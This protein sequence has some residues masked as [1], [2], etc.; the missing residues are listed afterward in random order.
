[1]SAVAPQTPPVPEE[2][3]QAKID[4]G[5]PPKSLRPGAQFDAPEAPM[6]QET[7]AADNSLLRLRGHEYTAKRVVLLVGAFLPIALFLAGVVMFMHVYGATAI[8]GWEKVLLLLVFFTPATIIF[9]V[10]IRAVY[11][12]Q[13]AKDST[14]HGE[15]WKAVGEVIKLSS[16]P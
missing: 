5:A 8:F 11:A 2:P 3:E 13:D 4:G 12:V 14:P 10:L 16:K 6:S 1:M 15:M 7:L 9:G